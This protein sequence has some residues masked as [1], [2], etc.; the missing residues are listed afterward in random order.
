M[1]YELEKEEFQAIHNTL[2][3]MTNMICDVVKLGM[4]KSHAYQMEELKYRKG[5]D[6]DKPTSAPL[7]NSAEYEGDFRGV[8]KTKPIEE[9]NKKKHFEMFSTFE[10]KDLTPHQIAG[11]FNLAKMVEF[12]LENFREDDK[13][14]PDRNERLE[15]IARDGKLAG[16]I[17]SYCMAV[18][19]L[20]KA[21]W[22][23]VDSDSLLHA[24]YEKMSVSDKAENIR[25]LAGNITQVCSIHLHPLADQFDYPNPIQF[26]YEE[27]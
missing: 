20:T 4:E 18:G 16:S 21:I 13:P 27:I 10:E 5:V 1:K 26:L 15:K 9:P 19:G 6:I 11:K 3:Q 14:Q 2:L 17:V 24:Y 12:W 8:S 23:T 7:A 22:N 25:Y